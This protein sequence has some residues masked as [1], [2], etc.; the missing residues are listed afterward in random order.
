MGCAPAGQSVAKDIQYAPLPASILSKAQ[1][2][3][4]GLRCNGAALKRASY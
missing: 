2:K 3:V 1:S 4:D